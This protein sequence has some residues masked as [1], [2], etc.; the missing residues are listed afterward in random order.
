M[1][2]LSFRPVGGLNG[3]ELRDNELDTFNGGMGLG[4]HLFVPLPEGTTS[5]QLR[6]AKDCAHLDK[7]YWE[8]HA[9]NHGWCC[10]DCGI[11]TQW[12]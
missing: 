3:I 10:A 7:S 8:A 1:S 11:I 5:K 9:G 12:G 2:K 6:K 4:Q